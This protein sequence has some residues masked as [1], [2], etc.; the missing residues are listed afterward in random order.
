[1]PL[2]VHCFSCGKTGIFKRDCKSLPKVDNKPKNRH[3]PGYHA[4]RGNRGVRCSGNNEVFSV[5]SENL[6]LVLAQNS[7]SKKAR[8]K[9]Q[10]ES[11]KVKQG[12]I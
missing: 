2:S 8:M 10:E 5:M 4:R 7:E 3:N 12:P 9:V 1:M 6:A 11:P